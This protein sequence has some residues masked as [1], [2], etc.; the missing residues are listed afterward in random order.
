MRSRW[1]DLQLTRVVR[2]ER[3]EVEMGE[4]CFAAIVERCSVGNS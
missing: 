4:K 3:E 2:E 1:M